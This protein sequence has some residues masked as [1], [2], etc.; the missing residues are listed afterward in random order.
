MS[1]KAI[2]LYTDEGDEYTVL[3]PMKWEICCECDGEGRH[4]HALGSFTGSEWAEESPEFREDYMNGQY[5]RRCDHCNGTGKVQVVDEE[6]FDRTNPAGCAAWLEQEE[7][8][9]A[10]RCEQDAERRMGA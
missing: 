1:S 5:D 9:Y 4:S 3:A 2:K 8:D 7:A 10:F 6:N